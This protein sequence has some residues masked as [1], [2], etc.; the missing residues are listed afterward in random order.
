MISYVVNAIKNPCG[1]VEGRKC[2][3]PDYSMCNWKS[4][5]K[6]GTNINLAHQILADI[7]SIHSNYKCKCIF[8]VEE[9]I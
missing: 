8:T 3:G 6:E 4:S 5:P 1:S 9:I 7:V 2:I